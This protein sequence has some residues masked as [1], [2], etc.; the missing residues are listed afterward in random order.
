MH[1]V[2][3]K[4]SIDKHS[5]K[6]NKYHQINNDCK[7]LIQSVKYETEMAKRQRKS[8][9]IIVDNATPIDDE[10]YELVSRFGTK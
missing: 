8:V 9:K 7:N 2:S 3:I 5:Q 1:E 10:T 4:K 6:I